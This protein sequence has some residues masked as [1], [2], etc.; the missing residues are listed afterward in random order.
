M[1]VPDSV[2][3]VAPSLVTEHIALPK[4]VAPAPGDTYESEQNGRSKGVTYASLAPVTAYVV[5]SRY[6]TPALAK[7]EEFRDE[8]ELG[9]RHE[10]CMMM[11]HEMI[12]GN[13]HHAREQQWRR[14]EWWQRY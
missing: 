7:D 12:G 10:Q 1:P 3:Y 11:I 6:G 5:A 13:A 9:R 4:Y 2:E 14:Q 8:R